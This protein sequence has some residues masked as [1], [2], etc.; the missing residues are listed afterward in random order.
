MVVLSFAS[1]QI[2]SFVS[3]ELIMF[4]I[5]SQPVGISEE[6]SGALVE[7]SPLSTPNLQGE[8]GYHFAY[9]SLNGVRQ[10][11]SSGVALN[12]VDLQISVPSELVAHYI[13]SGQDND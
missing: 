10:T 8:N 4:S 13:P 6:S 5:K 12:Q 1:S 11:S 2:S 7:G 3:D 9:W